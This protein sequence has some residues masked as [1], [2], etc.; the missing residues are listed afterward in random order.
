MK[1][2]VQPVLFTGLLTYRV[3]KPNKELNWGKQL[4]SRAWGGSG[5]ASASNAIMIAIPKLRSFDR[6]VA[7]SIECVAAQTPTLASRRPTGPNTSPAR[8]RL[9]CP[10]PI[11]LSGTWLLL[12]KRYCIP[13]TAEVQRSR[14]LPLRGGHWGSHNNLV[15]TLRLRLSWKMVA[16]AMLRSGTGGGGR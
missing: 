4:H 14:C 12:T 7:R 6:S 5:L 15:G 1:C 16:A 10:P 11:F 13:R 9:S 2:L 3:P 8:P